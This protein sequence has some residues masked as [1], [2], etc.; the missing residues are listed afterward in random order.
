MK[1]ADY[2]LLA[3]ILKSKIEHAAQLEMHDMVLQF[4]AIAYH[5]AGLAS[6]NKQAFLRACGID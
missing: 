1:K 2:A 6:V 3:H 5:F 4:R